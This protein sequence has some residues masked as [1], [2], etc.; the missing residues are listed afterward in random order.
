MSREISEKK[1]LQNGEPKILHINSIQPLDRF[2]NN[3]GGKEVQRKKNRKKT[4]R[5]DQKF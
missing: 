2:L 5:N 4:I 3:T 1:I